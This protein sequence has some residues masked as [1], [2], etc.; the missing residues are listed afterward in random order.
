M[1]LCYTVTKISQ[2]FFLTLPKD[3]PP[4]IFHEVNL[5]EKHKIYQQISTVLVDEYEETTKYS[6][7]QT[8]NDN[9]ILREDRPGLIVSST[10]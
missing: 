5:D 10:R 7:H 1:L 3:K 9:F 4:E 6:I 2:N 8:K